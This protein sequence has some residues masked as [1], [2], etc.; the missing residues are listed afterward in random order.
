MKEDEKRINE[1]FGDR[2]CRESPSLDIATIVAKGERWLT[3]SCSN[4]VSILSNQGT[5][6]SE[7]SISG[8]THQAGENRLDSCAG[9]S[10]KLGIIGSA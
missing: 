5:R 10:V 1:Y 9:L 6:L 7:M 3:D 4:L 8:S 2:R